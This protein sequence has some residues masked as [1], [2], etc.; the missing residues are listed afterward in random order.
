MNTTSAGVY[1]V[2]QLQIL[3][4]LQE[5]ERFKL[6]NER[7]KH[8]QLARAEQVCYQSVSTCRKYLVLADCVMSL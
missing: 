5:N 8:E 4:I 1:V 6:E 2:V 7:M 3:S